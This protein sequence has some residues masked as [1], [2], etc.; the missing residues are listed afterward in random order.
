MI[1]TVGTP[2]SDAYGVTWIG[3]LP[4]LRQAGT[5]PPSIDCQRAQGNARAP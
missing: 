3:G 2:G 1:V 4:H 5:P